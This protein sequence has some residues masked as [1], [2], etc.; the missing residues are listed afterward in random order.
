MKHDLVSPDSQMGLMVSGDFILMTE[1]GDPFFDKGA[2]LYV[3]TFVAERAVPEPLHINENN[4]Y[5]LDFYG[6]DKKGAPLPDLDRRFWLLGRLRG[7]RL[8]KSP[9]DIRMSIEVAAWSYDAMEISDARVRA[10]Y[11]DLVKFMLAVCQPASP[12]RMMSSLPGKQDVAAAEEPVE[13]PALEKPSEPGELDGPEADPSK[14]TEGDGT[15]EEDE[16][17]PFEDSDDEPEG[18]DKEEEE[19]NDG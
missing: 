10:A 6:H 17:I 12:E 13:P 15:V 1:E 19:E 11:P 18:P 8:S 16:F 7:A 5:A 14:P 9:G 4:I 3:R 2:D